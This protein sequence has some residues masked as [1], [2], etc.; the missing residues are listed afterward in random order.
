MF[1]QEFWTH[2]GLAVKT[3]LGFF[4]KAGWAFIF[5]YFVSSMIQVFVSKKRL[6]PYLGSP[7]PRSL[8]LAAEAGQNA[9]IAPC[10]M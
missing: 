4:W 6:A 7:G 2:Y 5:G 10:P 1:S 3:A 9:T 8:S